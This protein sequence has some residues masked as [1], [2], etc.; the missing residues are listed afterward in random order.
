MKTLFGWAVVA[1]A[2]AAGIAWQGCKS[3][4]VPVEGIL[5]T[6]AWGSDQG[7]LTATQVSTQ[8]SGACGSGNTNTPIMLDKHGRFDLVGIYGSA[9]SA[10]APARF[11]GSVASKQVLLRVKMA[12]SSAVFGPIV[13]NLGQQPALATCH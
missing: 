9:G 8:F 5:L 2:V 1:A 3:P 7:R 6:G 12:D 11:T 13:M 4:T 10:S